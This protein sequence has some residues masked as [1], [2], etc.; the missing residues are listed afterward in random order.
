MEVQRFTEHFLC[1]ALRLAQ[2]LAQKHN[3]SITEGM[4][5]SDLFPFAP[6]EKDKVGDEV[7]FLR[8]EGADILAEIAFATSMEP[9]EGDIKHRNKH[10]HRLAIGEEIQRVRKERG[11][12][13]EDLADRTGL[14]PYS[15]ARIEDGRW[16]LDI[17]QL[18]AIA[19]ALGAK[20]H[21]KQI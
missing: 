12:T 19:E 4:G 5:V 18:G 10:I 2:H 6:K 7:R 9:R 11:M 13:L 20:I 1:D 21:L 15:I 16:D 3:G 17:T 8:V 14:R